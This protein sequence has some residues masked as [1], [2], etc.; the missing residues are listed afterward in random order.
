MIKY[1]S[2]TACSV[3]G[4]SNFILGIRY[5]NSLTNY[6]F[7]NPCWRAFWVGTYQRSCGV[8]YR[9][10][11]FFFRCFIWSLSAVS[12]FFYLFCHFSFF[13]TFF[14][15]FFTPFALNFFFVVSLFVVFLSF[16]KFNICT[17]FFY[18]FQLFFLLLILYLFSFLCFVLFLTTPFIFF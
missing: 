14:L 2:N 12:Y 15:L 18:K 8:A 10:H 17:L 4:F 1:I 6:R 9:H 16:Y 3:T 11:A 5:H 13:F 7:T